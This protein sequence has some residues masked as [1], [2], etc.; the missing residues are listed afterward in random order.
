LL[1]NREFHLVLAA[2]SGNPHLKPFV[3]M[4]R[5]PSHEMLSPA[6]DHERILDAVCAGD[7][8]LAEHLTRNHVAA[9]PPLPPA[10]G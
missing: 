4:L 3:E 7:A 9:Y 8:T 10:P 5:V 1:A 2:A 6:G